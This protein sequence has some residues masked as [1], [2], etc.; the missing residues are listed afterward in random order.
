MDVGEWRFAASEATTDVNFVSL[1]LKM[2]LSIPR[3]VV[4]EEDMDLVRLDGDVIVLTASVAGLISTNLGRS[5]P[6]ISER[7]NKS[8]MFL[9][10]LCSGRNPR[11]TRP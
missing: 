10:I 2:A 9:S 3:A 7:C 4:D 6:R 1:A 11:I 5:Q 8:C